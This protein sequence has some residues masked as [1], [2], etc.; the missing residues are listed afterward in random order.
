LNASPSSPISNIILTII[1]RWTVLL[2]LDHLTVLSL[3]VSSIVSENIIL[4]AWGLRVELTDSVIVLVELLRL[5]LTV[6]V[7]GVSC[8]HHRTVVNVVRFVHVVL[9]S[10][11]AVDV[12]ALLR[13]VVALLRVVVALLRV[14]IALI[15][16]IVVALIV[17]IETVL[18]LII[19]IIVVLIISLHHALV[20]GLIWVVTVII[21]SL[22]HLN[23][24]SI[25]ICL[26][27]WLLL[28]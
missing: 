2:G 12:V 27:N 21:F 20:H 9:R 23:I 6:V 1:S 4:R 16:V 10:R 18:V 15:V 25:R 8:A 13:V 22:G 7:R 3:V 17:V 14:V 11:V 28:V 5:H 26:G 19:S 24:L